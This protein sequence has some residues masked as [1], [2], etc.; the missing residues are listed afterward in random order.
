MV[1][2]TY[3]WHMYIYIHIY[4]SDQATMPLVWNLIKWLFLL[5][6]LKYVCIISYSCFIQF[7]PFSQTIS[8]HLYIFTPFSLCLVL[9]CLVFVFVFVVFVFVFVLSCLV[10][11]ICQ[12]PGLAVKRSIENMKARIFKSNF[13]INTEKGLA[14]HRICKICKTVPALQHIRIYCQIIK[15]FSPVAGSVQTNPRRLVI[16]TQLVFSW[17]G[18]TIRH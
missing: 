11:H 10:L 9:S 18:A 8:P 17:A 14:F 7:S 5:W 1:R 13:S 3:D 6:V 2:F 16:D 15:Y 12:Y 4:V